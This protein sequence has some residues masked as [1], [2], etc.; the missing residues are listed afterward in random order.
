MDLL[1]HGALCP[2]VQKYFGGSATGSIWCG[3]CV[4]FKSSHL[5]VWVAALYLQLALLNL[6]FP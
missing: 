3:T 4:H 6:K 1:I 5:N 2:L